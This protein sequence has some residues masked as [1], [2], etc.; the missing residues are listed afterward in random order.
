MSTKQV[1]KRK[2]KV[3]STPTL[4]GHGRD[5]EGACVRLRLRSLANSALRLGTLSL[6]VSES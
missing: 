4:S 3:R 2:T 5:A 6:G 1:S